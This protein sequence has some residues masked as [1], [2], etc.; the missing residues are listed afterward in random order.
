LLLGFVIGVII[1]LEESTHSET[2]NSILMKLVAMATSGVIVAVFLCRPNMR[3]KTYTYL[4]ALPLLTTGLL[5]LP[6]VGA[7]VRILVQATLPTIWM[8]FIILSSAQL[9]TFKTKLGIGDTQLSFSEKA[10]VKTSW[11]IGYALSIWAVPTLLAQRPEVNTYVAM[12]LSYGLTIAATVAMARL[13]HSQSSSVAQ[14]DGLVAKHAA[15][16]P[17]TQLSMICDELAAQHGLTK[18]ERE[19]LEILAAGHSRPYIERTLVISG[20]TAKTHIYHIYERLGIQRK[21]GL[22]EL[23]ARHREPDARG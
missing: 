17:Q 12:A 22:L 5:V 9:S 4:S 11:T 14:E 18:R 1:G 20:S 16:S 21:E 3:S 7:S 2:E 10:V 6:F 15:P 23:V 8:S 19:V 13:S